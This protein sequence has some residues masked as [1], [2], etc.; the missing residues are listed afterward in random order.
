MTKSDIVIQIAQKTGIER[1][2]VSQT[3]E[4]FF[5]VVKNSLIAGEAIY[6]RGFGTFNVRKRAA[7]TG[8]NISTNTAVHIPEY[9]TPTFKPSKSF[10]ERVRTNVKALGE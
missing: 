9:H 8:R 4:T 7:K 5:K 1:E 10:V 6:V 3:L 2:E